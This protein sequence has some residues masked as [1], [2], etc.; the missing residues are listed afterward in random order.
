MARRRLLTEIQRGNEGRAVRSLRV[1]IRR[2]DVLSPLVIEEADAANLI[3][4]AEETIDL[5]G[6]G[7]ISDF[8]PGG[9]Q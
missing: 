5:I 7:R 1:F 3:T 9:P 2:V 8:G 4:G 6:L